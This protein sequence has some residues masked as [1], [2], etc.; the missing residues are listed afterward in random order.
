MIKQRIYSF[1]F[2]FLFFLMDTHISNAV[3]AIFSSEYK[4]S[5]H[6]FVFFFLIFLVHMSEKRLMLFFATLIAFIFDY[7]YFNQLGIFI[8]SLPLVTSFII[9][10]IQ[11]F[12]KVIGGFQLFL[13]FFIFIFLLDVMSFIAARYFSLTHLTLSYFLTF[14]MLP[15]LI[16]NFITFLALKNLIRK[17]KA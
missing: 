8:F 1:P 5:C 9:C 17:Q 13:L 7:Y 16:F 4:I 2:L 10:L 12:P 15:S 11:L 3:S 6:F 14:Q